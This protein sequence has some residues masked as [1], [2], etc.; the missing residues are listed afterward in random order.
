MEIFCYLLT[1]DEGQD[2]DNVARQSTN[3]KHDAT[4]E[5]RHQHPFRVTLRSKTNKLNNMGTGILLIV[6]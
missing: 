4:Q 5:S 3:E 2:G 1:L 6:L